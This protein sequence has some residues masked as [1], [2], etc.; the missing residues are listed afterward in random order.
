MKKLKIKK[1]YLDNAGATPMDSKVGRVISQYQKHFFANPS[2]IHQLGVEARNKV[3]GARRKIAE[4]ISAH[5]NEIIFTASGTESDALALVGL[6]KNYN[7]EKNKVNQIPH[8]ITTNIEHPAILENCH[9]LEKNNLAEI[10][11]IAVGENGIVDPK[12]IKD[13]L[14]DN[15]ILVSVMYANNEIGTIQPISNIA[16]EIRHFKKQKISKLNKNDSENQFPLFHTDACQAVNYL[17]MENIERLGVDLLSFNGSKIYGP[18]GIG[19]L[20][21]KKSV[22]L[23]PLYQ[24]GGQEFGLRSGTEN[25]TYIIGIAEAL[26]ETFRIKEKESVRLIK[27]RDY[28]VDKLMA[29]NIPSFQITLNGSVDKRLPNNINISISNISSELLVIELDALGLEVSEKSSCHSSDKNNSYVIKAIRKNCG[30]KKEFIEGSLRVSMGRQTTKKD[31]NIFVNS[32]IKILNK[33]KKW[34]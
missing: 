10:T 30:R 4:L 7:L 9:Y 14:K 26:K 11:Y 32:L 8:I 21:K 29:L 20:Y 27:L 28:T 3:E 17:P 22:E 19:I 25:V 5:S 18:K 33:Y 34:K 2:S 12:D 23:L 31:M 15:T 16:K 1:I 13:A 6:I 24:G